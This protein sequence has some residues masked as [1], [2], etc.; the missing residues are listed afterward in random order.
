MT[1]YHR[2]AKDLP[3]ILGM[4][5]FRD[6]FIALGQ[7]SESHDFTYQEITY[8]H[9]VRE[10][11]MYHLGIDSLDDDEDRENYDRILRAFGV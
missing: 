10:F 11:A 8:P 1:D 6:V 4:D 2:F 3:A 7:F 9:I 5:D